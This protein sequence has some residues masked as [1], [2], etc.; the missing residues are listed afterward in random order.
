MYIP[1]RRLSRTL[2]CQAK[3]TAKQ[4]NKA[5]DDD[6]YEFE[7][8]LTANGQERTRLNSI[9]VQRLAFEGSRVHVLER[10]AALILCHASR[11]NGK[12]L[13]RQLFVCGLVWWGLMGR[14]FRFAN[15][16]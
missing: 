1:R 7:V 6:V 12:G 16:V 11:L 13:G 4:D 9:V 10:N 3:P 14:G 2:R 5:D 15:R 8:E